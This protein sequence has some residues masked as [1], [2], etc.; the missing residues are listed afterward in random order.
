MSTSKSIAW[1]IWVLGSLFYAYQYILRVMPNLMLTD[2]M[3]QFHIDA[4]IFGQFSGV[5]YLGYAFMHLPLGLLLDRFGPRKVMS[6]CVLLSVIGILPILFAENW[7]YPVL[8]RALLGIG[9]SAAILGT[10]KIIRMTF[11]EKSFTRMLSL[12][13]TI[14]LLGAIYGG[15]PVSFLCAK[16]GYKMVVE[17]FAGLGLLLAAVIYILVPEMEA[18]QEE[19]SILANIKTV[20]TNPRV[21]ALCLLAGCMIG[22]LEGFADVWGAAFLRQAYGLDAD[23]ASYL[24]SM[25]FI[26]MCFGAPLLSLIA[27]KTGNYLGCIIGAGGLMLLVFVALLSQVL[28]VSAIAVGFVVVGVCCAYQI[29]AIYKA[30]TYVPEQVAGLTTAVANMI[31]MSFGYAFHSGIGYL[32]NLYGGPKQTQALIYGLSILPLSLSV[33]VVGLGVL[34]IQERGWTV[35]QVP[36]FAE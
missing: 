13:V 16:L 6:I 7:L 14:G 31:I 20:F 21:M 3:R 34:A 23:S 4:T 35:R 29:L 19:S 15:G 8:G 9:S 5:Y 24:S 11:N 30:S 1:S 27:E 10:F 2:L 22:P 28:S 36:A 32:V 25:I 33:A 26:G 17:I 12:S 18:Q